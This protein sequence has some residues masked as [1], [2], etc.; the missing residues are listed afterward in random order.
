MSR[1]GAKLVRVINSVQTFSLIY[2]QSSVSALNVFN[3]L[4]YLEFVYFMAK[5]KG[6][7]AMINLTQ[8]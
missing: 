6:A 1:G 4:F 2:G 7:F 3:V 8:C 5:C